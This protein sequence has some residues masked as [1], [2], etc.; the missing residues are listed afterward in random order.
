MSGGAP[1]LV[2]LGGSRA[3]QLD[4]S[5]RTSDLTQPR[6]DNEAKPFIKAKLKSLI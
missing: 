5:Q 2:Y 1:G 3:V 4:C 6:S